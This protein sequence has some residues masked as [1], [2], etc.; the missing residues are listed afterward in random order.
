[1]P[2][3]STADLTGHVAALR[4]AISRCVAWGSKRRRSM[5]RIN[6]V[7]RSRSTAV[8]AC[9]GDRVGIGYAWL[10]LSDALEEALCDVCHE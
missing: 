1:V 3:P 6:C 8:V 9:A 2:V 7:C 5:L 10:G 4:A